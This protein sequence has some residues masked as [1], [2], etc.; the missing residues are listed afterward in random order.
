LLEDWSGVAALFMVISALI[1][2]NTIR[3]AIFNR[4]EEIEM[5]KL[6]GASKAFIRGRLLSSV[7]LW[8]IAAIIA[9]ALV[10]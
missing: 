7:V 10:V 4:R 3:R 6:I 2:F 5:M 8:I 9:T 1:I